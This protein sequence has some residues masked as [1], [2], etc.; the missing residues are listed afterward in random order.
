MRKNMND[1]IITLG[2]K[3]ITLTL[4][5][6]KGSN[7]YRHVR[8]WQADG[9]EYRLPY[10]PI[11]S[12]LDHT[13]LCY[14]QGP[15]DHFF[16]FSA[17]EFS[18]GGPLSALDPSSVITETGRIWSSRK[19]RLTQDSHPDCPLSHVCTYIY[20]FITP[21]HFRS[22]TWLLPLIFRVASCA[23]N[24]WLTARSR[25][26]MQHSVLEPWECGV[27]SHCHYSHIHCDSEWLYLLDVWKLF[28]FDGVQ[29]YLLINNYTKHVNMNTIL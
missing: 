4:Y 14:L 28:V 29:K 27:P 3:N 17:K 15:T 9:D 5:F 12:F 16:C 2:Y 22:T 26:K 23:K 6:R 13:T 21:T 8:D 1:G 18:T 25:V 20:P 7:P 10:W 11:T 19:L 24:L